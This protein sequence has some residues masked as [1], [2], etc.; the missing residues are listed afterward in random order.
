MLFLI[1]KPIRRLIYLAVLLG[2]LSIG[3]VFV[4]FWAADQVETRAEQAWDGAASI[5]ASFSGFPFVGRLMAFGRVDKFEVKLREVEGQ[6]LKFATVGVVLDGIELDRG[7]FLRDRKV[8][9]T[10]LES[11]TVFAEITQEEISNFTG[12][13]VHFRPGR[14]EVTVAGQSVLAEVEVRD[15]RV[16][17]RPAGLVALTIPVPTS[18]YLPCAADGTVLEGRIRVGCTISEIP[19]ILIRE[20]SRA[21]NS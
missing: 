16:I 8:E 9:L 19:D 6:A 4:R 2:M 17:L 14:V 18:D 5:D 1:P 21:A 3:D 11:G 12:V 13:T 15:N 20:A 10:G 7:R